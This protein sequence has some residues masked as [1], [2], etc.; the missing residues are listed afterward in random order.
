MTIVIKEVTSA[1][2]ALNQEI[3]AQNRT[4]KFG[5]NNNT[6]FPIEIAF[7]QIKSTLSGNGWIGDTGVFQFASAGGLPALFDPFAAR[8]WK[9]IGQWGEVAVKIAGQ[10]IN[11]TYPQLTGTEYYSEITWN[12]GAQLLEGKLELVVKQSIVITEFKS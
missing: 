3:F 5:V 6:P 8:N 7:G 4:I 12:I 9:I 2:E 1:K 10:D 11:D